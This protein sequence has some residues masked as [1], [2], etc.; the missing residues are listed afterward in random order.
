MNEGVVVAA[1]ERHELRL[2]AGGRRQRA[3]ENFRH[4]DVG[5]PM[6][7]QHR[8]LDRRHLCEGIEGIAR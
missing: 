1:R 4:R 8:T 7:Y 5:S 3:T 6:S 2:R